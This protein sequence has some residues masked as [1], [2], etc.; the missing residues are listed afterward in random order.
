[1]NS[2]IIVSFHPIMPTKC[3]LEVE[4][5]EIKKCDKELYVLVCFEK[6]YTKAIQVDDWRRGGGLKPNIH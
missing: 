6:Y 1:V 4:V 5:Q 3:C 2:N